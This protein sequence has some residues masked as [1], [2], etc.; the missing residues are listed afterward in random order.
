MGP[1]RK[2]VPFTLSTDQNVQIPGVGISAVSRTADFLIADSKRPTLLMA[3]NNVEVYDKK[4]KRYACKD[5][6][7][8]FNR[9]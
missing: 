3:G 8:A 9:T 2:I 7:T 1:S 6:R 5:N 4:S